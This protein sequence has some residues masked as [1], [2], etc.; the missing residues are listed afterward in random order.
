MVGSSRNMTDGLLISSKAIERRFCWPPERRAPRVFRVS[1]RLSC[2]SIS[3]IYGTI[4]KQNIRI[5]NSSQKRNFWLSKNRKHVLFCPF[6]PNTL[7]FAV[8]GNLTSFDACL[9]SFFFSV[10]LIERQNSS[11]SSF[12][13]LLCPDN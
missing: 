3:F 12:S 5:E 9:A 2:A 7:P 1:V 13:Q 11:K 4:M 10:S 8:S 6:L